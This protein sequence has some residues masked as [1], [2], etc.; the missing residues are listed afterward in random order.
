M[1]YSNYKIILLNK[2][3]F[4]LIFL[5]LATIYINFGFTV[6]NRTHFLSYGPGVAASGM[7]E[8][9]TA[10]GYDMSV[11]YYNPSLLVNLEGEE[12]AANHWFL[13]DGA[14][15]NFIGFSS[16]M[17]KS[18]FAIAGTQLYRDNIE[19]RQTI[20][21]EGTKTENNQMA[22][23]GA[24]AGIIDKLNLNYGVSL[25]W[26]NFKMY[27]EKSE[28]LSLD[29]GLS[30]NLFLFGN[31][32]GKKLSIDSGLL[33]QNPIQWKTKMREEKEDL[34]LAVILGL[35]GKKTIFPKYRKKTDFL[36]YDEIKLATDFIYSEE[37]LSCSF[38]LEYKTL[39]K[40]LFRIGW[41]KGITAGFGFLFSDF[42]IDYAFIS[43][44]FT[45]FHKIGFIYRFGQR[46]ENQRQG[47]Y[48]FT[49]EYQKVYQRAKRVYTRYYR[50]AALLAEQD[51]YKEVIVLLKKTIPLNPKENKKAKELLAICQQIL[52]TKKIDNYITEAKSE[53][54]KK[55][56]I[57]AYKCYLDAFDLNP[58]NQN[59]QQFLNDIESNEKI[60]ANKKR[61]NKKIKNDYVQ[62]AFK[63]INLLLKKKN[64]E[65]A[66]KEIKKLYFID[67]KNK[68]IKTT[69]RKIKDKKGLYVYSFVSGGYSYLKEGNFA[70]AYLHFLEA[71]KL[72]PND[73]SI[74][75]QKNIAKKKFLSKRKF[76][77]EDNLYA[78]KLYYLAAYN[79]ATDES[80]LATYQE[81]KSFNPVHE[82][83]PELEEVLIEK[84]L[85]QKRNP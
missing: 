82:Y 66:E 11:I 74:S 69:K 20:E 9:Y 38:G 14:R 54:S 13:Y 60:S 81:L 18:A 53:H 85:I 84:K 67:P 56:Y 33:I 83:L 61:T 34:P 22:V 16:C 24:Y 40:A 58:E 80:P 57:N 29:I 68:I 41:K 30:R 62:K 35:A 43:K 4:L 17:E 72:N 2:K 27:T 75:D 70:N 78:D 46:K 1:L 36:S 23:Y 21:D 28:A 59:I 51:K 47:A 32:T 10:I 44:D 65:S 55:H 7:G 64:F 39:E 12:I 25:K 76:T 5:F 77:I 26:M 45:D 42:Q 49:D 63:K 37:N 52:T 31:P 8:T 6:G 19:V 71:E 15:Y 73:T 50:D 79:F 48:T 3:I